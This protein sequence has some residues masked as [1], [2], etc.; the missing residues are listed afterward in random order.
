[1]LC[2]VARSR[3]ALRAR[4][5][6]AHM[7][8]LHQ[9]IAVCGFDAP[10]R[11]QRAALDAEILLDAIEQRRIP[12]QCHLAVDDAP[13]GNATV[14]VLPDLL[15]ELGLIAD[16]LE[17]AHVRLDVAHRPVPGCF[18]N[19]FGECAVAKAVAPLVEAGRCCAA[20]SERRRKQRGG[21]QTRAQ[22]RAARRSFWGIALVHDGSLTVRTR[23]GQ[24]KLLLVPGFNLG[25]SRQFWTAS[26]A[27]SPP[28]C[29]STRPPACAPGRWRVGGILRARSSR[30]R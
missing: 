28:P 27:R 13:V 20:C 14:D 22:Q 16:L 8:L 12:L 26:G 25:D 15:G 29:R 11:E 18:R 5:N 19:A 2:G 3:P 23:Q 21:T 10:E 4:E 9:R 1:M 7:A 30:G 17:H 6:R 24:S